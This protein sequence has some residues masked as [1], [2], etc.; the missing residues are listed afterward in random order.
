MKKKELLRQFRWL[1]PGF[2][3]M[4]GL[5]L[6]ISAQ[7]EISAHPS[8]NWSNPSNSW[9]YSQAEYIV[10]T[11][12]VKYA[13]IFLLI[14]ALPSAVKAFFDSKKHAEAAKA[15]EVY[16]FRGGI[17]SCPRCGVSVLGEVGSCPRCG[18]AIIPA[19]W[20]GN[21]DKARTIVEVP[22][23]TRDVD[24]VLEACNSIFKPLKYNP[25]KLNGEMVWESGLDKLKLHLCLSAAFTRNSVLLQGWVSD[26][27][28]ESALVG[29]SRKATR[30][31]LD[32]AAMLIRARNL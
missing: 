12:R 19:V 32:K 25:K 20:D 7:S 15:M 13:G 26:F 29:Y 16:N 5:I 14:F 31:M 9:S 17:V 27:T 8:Y 2:L 6:L 18:T 4:I 24:G 22:M 28:G 3:A 1:L 21:M 23:Q 11:L 30:E 10:K